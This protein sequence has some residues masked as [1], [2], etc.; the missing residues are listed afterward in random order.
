[1]P[2]NCIN[3]FT[4]KFSH[5]LFRQQTNGP[6]YMK[7]AVLAALKSSINKPYDLF[8]ANDNT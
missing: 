6:Y 2:H 7:P 8:Q 4:D 1:M 3:K 5:L